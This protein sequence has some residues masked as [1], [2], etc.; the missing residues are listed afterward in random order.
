ME[1]YLKT[2]LEQIRCKKA[3]WEIREELLAHMTD[4]KEANMAKGMTEEEAE[5]CAV[6]DMGDPVETGIALDKVHR[7]QAA[8]QMITVM[9]VISAASMLIHWR[10]GSP[11]MGVYILTGFVLMLLIYHLDF[12]R[13][14]GAAKPLAI[15]FLVIC[16]GIF[17]QI[18]GLR[19]AGNIWI[20]V[21]PGFGGIGMFQAMMLYVPL[22]GAV[23]YQYYGTGY[24]GLLKGILWALP[25]LLFTLW[26]PSLT[27]FGILYVSMCS[28]LLLAVAKG[29]FRVAKNDCIYLIVTVMVLIP[30]LFL[31]VA[32]LRGQVAPY[33]MDRIRA[34]LNRDVEW[35]YVT[36]NMRKLLT[37]SSF[38]G[39][40]AANI[41]EILPDYNNSWILIYLAASYGQ[42]AFLLVCVGLV[43]LLCKVFGAVLGV[44]IPRFGIFELLS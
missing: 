26:M 43:F 21:L 23:L 3:Q 16:A 30:V 9:A 5:K 6:A 8:W 13:I 14:A 36:N 10:I 24:K 40:S 41:S 44:W 34:F 38:F 31:V 19:Y 39:T 1:E 22:Y 15:L 25:P 37:E 2:V 12:T 20:A 17:S 18:F 29:W 11:R 4:Q 42:V 35:N 33:Q 7:P 28:L 27:L 32:W